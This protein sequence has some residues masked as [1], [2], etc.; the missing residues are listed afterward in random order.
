MSGQQ[1]PETTGYQSMCE[2]ELPP[3]RDELRGREPAPH[4]PECPLCGG[5]VAEDGTVTE[6][7]AW[8]HGHCLA[9][10]AL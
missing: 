2:R 8:A 7:G 3:T 6:A 4:W 1:Q 9:E 10:P 5:D